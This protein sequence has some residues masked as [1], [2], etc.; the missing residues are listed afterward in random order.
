MRSLRVC[1]RLGGAGEAYRRKLCDLISVTVRAIVT[2]CV[3]DAAKNN[4]SGGGG[5][6]GGLNGDGDPGGA[7]GTMAG[8][9]QMSLDQFFD[10]IDMLFEQVLALLWGAFAVNRFCID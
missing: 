10:C 5:G 2:E 6:S 4:S 7:R 8:V 3:A 1:G 9:A